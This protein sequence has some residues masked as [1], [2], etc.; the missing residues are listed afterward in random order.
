MANFDLYF[1]QL[2]RFEGGYVDDPNDPGGATNKGITLRTFQT[3]AER[4][5]NLA[6]TLAN[7]QALSD[8]QAG[9]LYRALYWDALRCDQIQL[10]CLAED[11][12]DFY[13]NAG[14]HA[15]FLIQRLLGA[16]VAVDGVFGHDSLAALEAADQRTLYARY[17]QGRIDYYRLLAAQH[18]VL[19]RF[20]A[21]WLRRAQWFPVNAP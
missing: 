15:V 18:P 1:P 14:V 7:L 19:T 17:R 10:Q 9:V 20:L 4:V 5:L 6:P 16:P 2:L 13:V 8:E 11:L 12:F 3:Y 21:G